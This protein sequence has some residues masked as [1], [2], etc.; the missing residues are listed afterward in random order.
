MTTYVA[1]LRGINVGGKTKVEMSKL[2]ACFEQQGFSNVQTYINSGNVIFDSNKSQAAVIKIIE[3]ILKTSFGFDIKV[4]VRNFDQI[5]N[6][7]AKIPKEWV[8]D[9]AMRT[10]VIFLRPEID[11]KDILNKI[12]IKPDIENIIYIPGAVVWNIDRK[13]V[14]RGSIVKLI[15]TDLYRD[16]TIRNVNTVRKLAK[17]M[18]NL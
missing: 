12:N 2:K 11:S 5:Q 1:L 13:N 10:D 4:V 3:D 17:L 16:M 18:N 9:I 14:T 15:N 8:N 6:L 7:N